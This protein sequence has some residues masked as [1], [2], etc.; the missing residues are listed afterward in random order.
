MTSLYILK[1][2]VKSTV[3]TLTGNIHEGVFLDNESLNV[4]KKVYPDLKSKLYVDIVGYGTYVLQAQCL[5][6]N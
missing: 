6:Y 2:L 5:G 3:F 4:I 1:N